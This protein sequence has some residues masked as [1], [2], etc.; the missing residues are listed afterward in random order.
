MSSSAQPSWPQMV[1]NAALRRMEEWRLQQDEEKRESKQEKKR[2]L[3]NLIRQQRPDPVRTVDALQQNVMPEE[4]LA[5]SVLGWHQ[6]LEGA[7]RSVSDG[8]TPSLVRFSESEEG[9]DGDYVLPMEFVSPIIRLPRAGESGGECV[10]PTDVSAVSYFFQLL[11]GAVSLGEEDV[12]QLG[13][14]LK[15]VMEMPLPLTPFGWALFFQRCVSAAEAAHLSTPFRVILGC[16]L[17]LVTASSPEA[18]LVQ[19]NR[20]EACQQLCQA[21]SLW[22]R[23]RLCT[24]FDKS[25]ELFCHFVPHL[26]EAPLLFQAYSAYCGFWFSYMEGAVLHGGMIHPYQ[27]FSPHDLETRSTRDLQEE[28]MRRCPHSNLDVYLTPSM[29]MAHGGKLTPHGVAHALAKR[30]FS[31]FTQRYPEERLQVVVTDFSI[32]LRP[33]AGRERAV[34]V[35]ALVTESEGADLIFL[36]HGVH[37]QCVVSMVRDRDA[38]R[39]EREDTL[40][41][42]N[43]EMEEE[44]AQLETE[45]QGIDER[46]TQFKE[47]AKNRKD[48]QRSHLRES[49]KEQ[50][51]LQGAGRGAHSFFPQHQPQARPLMT[52]QV[53]FKDVFNEEEMEEWTQLRLDSKRCKKQIK[54]VLRKQRDAREVL[55]ARVRKYKLVCMC[56]SAFREMVESEDE[57]VPSADMDVSTYRRFQLYG[58]PMEELED[59]YRTPTYRRPILHNLENELVARNKFRCPLNDQWSQ[60]KLRKPPGADKPVS[61]TQGVE[62]HHPV[63]LYMYSSAIDDYR[64]VEAPHQT[65]MH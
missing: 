63:D 49:Q 55:M 56:S 18:E 50:M 22:A 48:V 29:V 46:M 45:F 57:A 3:E 20:R 62:M 31:E 59:K 65:F 15:H 43:T 44:K 19:M 26:Y 13:D 41:R 28:L 51:S 7:W 60:V 4:H 61:D 1:S 32:T 10:V 52:D 53:D 42:F 5:H 16:L 8:V 33:L 34:T 23:L 47:E 30:M 36:S 25:P 17:S 11:Q 24:P 54:E 27:V 38:E 39:H 14:V 6:A 21:S 2:V 12:V 35:Y 64:L 9:G 37:Q 58:Y 40:G